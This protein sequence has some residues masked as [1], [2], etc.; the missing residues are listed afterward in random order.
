MQ[1][2][3]AR[4][5]RS[6]LRTEG[7]RLTHTIAV[8]PGDGIGP[9]VTAEA[10]KVLEEAASRCNISYRTVFYPFGAEHYLR[11]SETIPDEAFE[12]IKKSHAV[13][14]GAVGDPRV[15]P[16]ILERGI[17]G[18]LRWGLDLYVNL[19]P[20]VLYHEAL[21]PIKGKKPEDINFTVV[22]ENTED[23]Y[24]GIGGF[25]KEGTPDEIA[26]FNLVY[27]RKGVERI[28]RYAFDLARKRNGKKRVT[29]CD[30][31]NAVPAHGLWRRV[32]HDVGQE[33]PDLEKDFAYVDA[34]CMWM[35]KKPEWFDVI[36]TTNMFGD[37]ITDLGAELTGGM[38]VAASANLYP[39]RMGMFE[40]IH[41]SAPKYAGKGV[42]SP[43][44]AIL[45]VGMMLEFLGEEEGGER[46]VKGV[47][48]L[49]G[50]GRLTDLS[51]Q[52]GIKASTVTSMVLE[53]IRE[54]KI[55]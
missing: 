46:V 49:L 47:A 54:C 32:F 38:G 21:T 15:S 35:I 13:F 43:L 48:S 27:S 50:S 11:T 6:A 25:F 39:D 10:M 2:E 34:L 9:E 28:I 41:G 12:E 14:L 23:L 51:A 7:A 8:I 52:S 24:T 42:A 40:P 4:N 1:R 29:L 5:E 33:Y 16:G 37:I 31:A 26:V 45:A 3:G 20:V 30:K 19:R 53:E 36:V 18:R 17:V 44:A 55:A 22:R